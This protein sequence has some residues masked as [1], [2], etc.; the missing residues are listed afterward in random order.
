MWWAEYESRVKSDNGRLYIHKDPLLKQLDA[1]SAV[2]GVAPVRLL[3]LS[4]LEER[5]AK[6]RAAPSEAARRALALPRRQELEAKHPEAFLSPAEMR[7][8]PKG[9]GGS[10]TLRRYAVGAHG[11]G[12]G[13]TCSGA[14]IID[15]GWF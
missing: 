14:Y 8:L 4:W 2:R 9:Y 10:E 15:G 13:G 12:R 11:V 3:K 6:L 1:A 5:A 7:A